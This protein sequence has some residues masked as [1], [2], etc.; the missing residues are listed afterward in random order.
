MLRPFLRARATLLAALLSVFAPAAQAAD[1]LSLP[2][3]P[4]LP[5]GPVEWGSNWY[6]RGD[7]GFQ[8]VR[9][10]PLSANVAAFDTKDLLSGGVGGGYQFNDWLRADITV[11]RSVFRKSGVV[12]QIWCP[13][14]LRELV[15]QTT[16]LKIGIFADPNDTC[17][18]FGQASLT[19]TSVLAN[20]YLDLGH[21]WGF[22]PYLGA[23]VGMSYLSGS[24]SLAYLRNSDGG[25]WAPDLTLPNGAVPY[26]V[27]VNGDPFPIQI[28]FAPT[29]WNTT[30]TKAG[31]QFAW[32]LM[33]GVSY[34]VARNF[35]VDIGYRYL[36]AGKYT[37]LPAYVN[38]AYLA[39]AS[40]EITSHEL[41]VGFRVTTN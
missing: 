15:D 26:W 3:A 34:D 38:G 19:R 20:A 17:S 18:Q 4:E 28:P 11:D 36:N 5:E 30:Q 9:V 41:R 8:Q 33:A 32:N 22:T 35:K 40:R 31:W 21:F 1:L 27:Y 14:Q 7:V 2:E 25:L 16:K 39:P 29:N 10:P 24:S 13:N 6:L 37:G 23:G 12:G